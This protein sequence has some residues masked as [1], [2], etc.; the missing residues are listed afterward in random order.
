MTCMVA[1]LEEG[2]LVVGRQEAPPVW[3]L[4]DGFAIFIYILISG[5]PPFNK[6]SA[7]DPFFRRLYAGGKAVTKDA[8]A[9]KLAAEGATGATPR[10]TCWPCAPQACSSRSPKPICVRLIW[11]L[12]QNFPSP[13][14]I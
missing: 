7:R 10:V 11:E 1:R 14:A 5:H 8:L 6:A 13:P 12:P 2:H 3:R 9:R 4:E